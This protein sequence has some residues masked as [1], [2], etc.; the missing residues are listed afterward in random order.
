MSLHRLQQN[1][2]S[3][4]SSSQRPPRPA[5]QHPHARIISVDSIQAQQLPG[6]VAVLTANDIPG[7]KNH[8]LLTKDW[9]VLAC[10][11]VRYVGDALALIAAE[12]E[13]TARQALKLIS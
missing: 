8:G 5:S 9:P 7:E 12:S 6:V 4:G 11:K 10:D 13:E 2:T 3:R 1:Y